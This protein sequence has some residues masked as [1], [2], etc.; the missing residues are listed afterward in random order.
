MT[1]SSAALDVLSPVSDLDDD[2]IVI[3]ATPRSS[4]NI[5]LVGVRYRIFPP[6]TILALLIANSQT[7][8]KVRKHASTTP[9]DEARENAAT[10]LRLYTSIQKW[11]VSA[12]GAKDGAKIIGRL[13]DP[14]DELDLKNIMELIRR[15]GEK[16]T[17]DPTS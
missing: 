17:G 14:E 7:P 13:E 4:T 9:E 12:F 5:T 11:I 10:S 15:V 1:D 3:E 2:E 16:K 6:K 8:K